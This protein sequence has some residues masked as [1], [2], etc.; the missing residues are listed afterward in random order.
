MPLALLMPVSRALQVLS[1]VVLISYPLSLY[2]LWGARYSFLVLSLMLIDGLY[3]LL[4][5]SIVVLVQ[6][7]GGLHFLGTILIVPS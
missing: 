3:F 2:F 6:L 7:G 4:S 1:I 5:L